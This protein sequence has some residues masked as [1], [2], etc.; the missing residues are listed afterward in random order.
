MKYKKKF[1]EMLDE[2]NNDNFWKLL[3]DIA[4]KLKTRWGL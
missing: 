1:I 2:V 4:V 3:Y